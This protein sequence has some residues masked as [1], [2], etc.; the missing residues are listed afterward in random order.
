MIGYCRTVWGAI[1]NDERKRE[2]AFR[3]LADEARKRRQREEDTYWYARWTF[4]AAIA[5][6]AIGI[7]G[8][9]VSVVFSP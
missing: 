9:I 7:I 4:F 1:Y 6:A 5:A 2:A 8:V 3:W